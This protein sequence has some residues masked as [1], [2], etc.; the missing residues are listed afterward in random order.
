MNAQPD[1]DLDLDVLGFE[2]A[3]RKLELA[4]DDLESGDLGL[5]G[6]L[7][8]YQ[9]GVR[10]LSHCYGLLEGAERFVALLDGVDADGTPATSPFD[11][12]A[13]ADREAGK[14]GRPT[15]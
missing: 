10:L 5:D 14:A 4:V 6:A 11:A 9:L 1:L 2:D 7:L 15:T 12:K 3:M 8:R 13:T